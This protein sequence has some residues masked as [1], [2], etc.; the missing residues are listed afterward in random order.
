MHRI[1][2]TVVVMLCSIT[3]FSGSANNTQIESL[4]VV[5]GYEKFGISEQ[6]IKRYQEIMASP[7]GAFYRRGDANILYVL[8]AES[9]NDAQ[10]MHYARLWVAMEGEYADNISASLKAYEVA[11]IE[12]WGEEPRLFDIYPSH[13]NQIS[14]QNFKSISKPRVRVFVRPSNCEECISLSQRELK[15]FHSGTLSG[16]DFFFVGVE[17]NSALIKQWARDNKINPQLVKR[18]LITLNHALPKEDEKNIP[19]IELSFQ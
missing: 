18:R 7:M 15:K 3:S 2:L 1:I 14:N 6:D 16:V 9:D 17:G 19:R 12:R 11:S 5:T 13:R 4:K 8:T 10:R